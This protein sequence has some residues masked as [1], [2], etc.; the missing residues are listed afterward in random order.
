MNLFGRSCRLQAVPLT[1]LLVIAAIPANQVPAGLLATEPV[2][3]VAAADKERD[4]IREFV[5][6]ED[7]RQQMEA[8]GVD[9]NEA[10]AGIEGLS[11]SEIQQIAVYVAEEEP[12]GQSAIAAV[13]GAIL[14]ILV[15]LVITDLFGYTHVFPFARSQR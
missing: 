2:I 15:V 3:E 8:L 4:R 10:A 7:V 13:L 12:A 5:E 6:R 14:F 9:P 11:D 1:I